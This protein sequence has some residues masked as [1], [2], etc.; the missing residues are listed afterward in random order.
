MIGRNYYYHG[1]IKKSIVAFGNLFSTIR[2]QTKNGASQKIRDVPVPISYAKKQQWYT[3]L[4]EDPKFL[5]KFE[6]DIPRL[7]FEVTS[8]QYLSEK[9]LGQS[10]SMILKH[11]QGTKGIYAPVPYRLGFSLS[12][13]TKNVEDSLQI[14]EQILPYFKP[15]MTLKIDS[16][17][18][19]N[20]ALEFPLVFDGVNTEDNYQDLETNRMIIDEFNFHMDIILFGPTD[21]SVNMIKEVIVDV[22]TSSADINEPYDANYN[23]QVVPRA[24]NEDDPHT[25]EEMWAGPIE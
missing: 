18:D 1:T 7:S 14:V 4:Q 24:A 17:P 5:K 13:Y 20:I 22:N 25:I 23:A 11:C 9:N 10:A 3:R 8:Y 19:M 15:A 16:V 12:S 2:I 21:N 6:T